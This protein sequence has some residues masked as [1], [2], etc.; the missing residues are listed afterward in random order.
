[1]VNSFWN[2]FRDKFVDYFLYET[3]PKSKNS[4]LKVF[5]WLK[6]VIPYKEEGY[7]KEE[8][9]R[10]VL[11]FLFSEDR[12]RVVLIKKTKPSW[13]AGCLNGVG[14]K[15]ESYDADF[16]SAMLR[17]F[18][19]ETGVIIPKENWHYFAEMLDYKGE[20]YVSCYYS[21]DNNNLIDTVK[22]MEEESIAV[23]DVAELSLYKRVKNL[24]WLIHLALDGETNITAY[25]N[26]K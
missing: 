17:E 19:E 9:V 26:V 8:T 3:G 14:G 15:L 6:K 7:I 23:Y 13:Q 24:E 4:A 2:N 18:R 22:T 16:V 11:G 5:N 10:F 12:K 20:F 21:I 1:M 25:Y